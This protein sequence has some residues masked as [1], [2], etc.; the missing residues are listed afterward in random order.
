MAYSVPAIFTLET[1]LGSFSGCSLFGKAKTS[2]CC[3][4]IVELTP[5]AF[6]SQNEIDAAK[7]VHLD[8]MNTQGQP[9]FIWPASF[10]L[11]RAYVDQLERSGGLSAS[12]IA[13]VRQALA[14]AEQASGSARSSALSQLA[15]QI[16]GDANGSSDSA[17]VQKLGAAVRDL[18]R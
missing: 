2:H 6:I 10:S 8:Y 17:K 15:S 18:A 5:S 11:A 14:S 12:R 7:S 1:E 4:D 13:G 16:D 9:K 3:F